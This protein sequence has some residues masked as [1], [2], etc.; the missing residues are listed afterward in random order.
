MA[1][2][3]LAMDFFPLHGLIHFGYG[4]FSPSNEEKN[5]YIVLIACAAVPSTHTC[6]G[7]NHILEDAS[8]T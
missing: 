8:Q 4:L 6:L 2:S 7:Q 1:S 5:Y 3:I